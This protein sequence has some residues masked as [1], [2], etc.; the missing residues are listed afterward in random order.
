MTNC[1]C[2]VLLGAGRRIRVTFVVEDDTA[3]PIGIQVRSGAWQPSDALRWLL[4]VIEPG[5]RV[6]DLGGHIGTFAVPAAVLGAHVTAVEASPTNA[7]LLEAAAEASGVGDRLTVVRRAVSDAP[8]ILEFSDAGPY[9]TIAT[10]RTRSDGWRAVQVEATTI[11]TLAVDAGGDFRWMKIDIEGAECSALSA[12]RSTLD[13]LRGLVIESNGFM[14]S[15]H[16]CSA[17]RLLGLLSGAGL[18]VFSVT[19]NT[20]AAVDVSMQAVTTVDYVATHGVPQLPDGWQ[21]GVPPQRGDVVRSLLAEL[22]HPVPQHRAYALSVATRAPARIRWLPAIR[23]AVR[24]LAA[25]DNPYV[26]RVG[27]PA[28][29][30]R[31]EV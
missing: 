21:I 28:R 4:S 14:L 30:K 1:V 25:D 27:I 18:G 24:A 7:A 8:G 11:D 23:K 19:G 15:E 2:D 6:L 13:G 16:G 29:A 9:G 10:P 26:K 5:D 3:D 22:H 31:S 17:E 12:G 20:L